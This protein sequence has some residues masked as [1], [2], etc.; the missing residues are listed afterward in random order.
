MDALESVVPVVLNG[1]EGQIEVNG[2]SFNNSMPQH[3]FLKDEEI[4]NVLTYIRQ[5]F[6]N[7]A[8]AIATEE[9]QAARD[10]SR[11]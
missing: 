3:S 6:G 5:N 2:L 9:V 7:K 11:P 4:A 1:L 10:F 8:S